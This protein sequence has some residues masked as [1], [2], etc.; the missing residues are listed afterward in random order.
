MA[1]PIKQIFVPK[2]PHSRDLS[3]KEEDGLKHYKHIIITKYGIV[4]VYAITETKSESAFTTFTSVG[5]CERLHCWTFQEYIPPE[6]SIKKANLMM[7][8]LFE[9]LNH[10]T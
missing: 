1:E 5:P 6:E 4:S 7:K 8:E 10:T 9:Q 3:I 2:I